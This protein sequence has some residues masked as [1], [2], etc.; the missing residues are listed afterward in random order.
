[1]E[2]VEETRL[3]LVLNGGVSLAVWMGGVTHELDLLRRAS[4]SL[5]SGVPER[6]K[7]E[8]QASFELWQRVIREAHTRVVVDAVAGA[9][10]GG[11]NGSFLAA[12]IGRGTDLPDLRATWQKAAALTG[13]RLLKDPPSSTAYHGLPMCGG[14]VE[15]RPASGASAGRQPPGRSSERGRRSGAFRRTGD[16]PGFRATR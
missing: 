15:I 12:A 2:A 13:D 4:R 10:A 8:D 1:M 6:V 14:W 7:T 3:A 9:S 16:L 5:H 11:L